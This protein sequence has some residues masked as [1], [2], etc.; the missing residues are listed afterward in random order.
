[1]QRELALLVRSHRQKF[2]AGEFVSYEAGQRIRLKRLCILM[3]LAAL[4]KYV[5]P[6]EGK[7]MFATKVKG[8]EVTLS[9]D[10]DW[11]QR[12]PLTSAALESE[13]RYLKKIGFQLK[14]Q[15]SLS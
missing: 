3:R 4:F 10:A 1:M 6:V 5:T 2:P 13:Q 14:F 12:H 7:P 11:L 15:Q 9:F 8:S